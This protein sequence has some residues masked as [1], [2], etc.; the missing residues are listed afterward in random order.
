[1]SSVGNDNVYKLYFDPGTT[2]IAISNQNNIIN[3]YA[4]VDT[5]NNSFSYSINAGRSAA[6]TPILNGNSS[7]S[8]VAPSSTNVNYILTNTVIGNSGTGA[9]YTAN[10]PS[11]TM[12]GI[13]FS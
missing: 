11:I 3:V 12:N 8:P 7:T 9:K 4:F 6:L 5:G 1:L 13:T 2:G 10:P